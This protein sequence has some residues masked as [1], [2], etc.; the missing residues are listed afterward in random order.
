MLRDAVELLVSAGEASTAAD[1][2]EQQAEELFFQGHLQCLLSAMQAL[3]PNLAAG[4]PALTTWLAWMHLAS[5]QF[6]ACMRNIARL[7]GS[8]GEEAGAPRQALTCLLRALVAAQ[9]DDLAAAQAALP[10]LFEMHAMQQPVLLGGR[11]LV[12]A[13]YF[14]HQGMFEETH[15]L[16]QGPAHHLPDGRVLRDS[17]FGT[18]M[19][20]VL[21]GMTWLHQGQYRQAESLL[22][23]TYSNACRSLGPDCLAAHGAAALLAE[24]LIETGDPDGARKL[25]GRHGHAV[26]RSGVPDMMLSAAVARS[27]LAVRDGSPSTALAALEHALRDAKAHNMRRLE[28]ALLHERFDIALRTKDDIQ[29]QRDLD[30]LEAVAERALRDYH[31]AAAR[32]AQWAGLSRARWHAHRLRDE[33][34]LNEVQGLESQAVLSGWL[35]VQTGALM[36]ILMRRGGKSSISMQQTLQVV[37]LAQGA[38]MLQSVIDLGPAFLQMLSELQRNDL[39]RNDAMLGLY[40]QKLLRISSAQGNQVT[41]GV[42]ASAAAPAMSARELQ[43][44]NLL[45]QDLPNR[46]IGDALGVSTETIRWHLKNIFSKLGVGRRNDAVMAARQLGLDGVAPF[47]AS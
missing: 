15:G 29:A 17:P 3:P 40:L 2:I 10:Q 37:Q 33:Q 46:R 4:R 41:P 39:I 11:R 28:A 38:G 21:H 20:Q 14:L 47:Q 44:L 24:V 23:D 12:L 7:E 42:A 5:R 45:T 26:E 8:R 43:I 18:F 27:R 31:P 36:A 35:R 13:W 25:L 19:A 16:L 34:A 1:W 30:A 22:R 32:I 6:D 9:M